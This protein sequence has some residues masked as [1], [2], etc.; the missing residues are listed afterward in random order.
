MARRTDNQQAMRDVAS[1]GQQMGVRGSRYSFELR[2]RN[3]ESIGRTYLGMQHLHAFAQAYAAGTLNYN[4][5]ER[6]EGHGRFMGRSLVLYR[7]LADNTLEPWIEYEP[8]G[9]VQET[10]EFRAYQADRERRNAEKRAELEKR[11]SLP[12]SATDAI[13]RMAAMLAEALKGAV[14]KE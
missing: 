14:G 12:A 5:R 11:V 10:E 1:D 4:E 8:D 7:V 6:D 2:T 9:T 13:D 3:N